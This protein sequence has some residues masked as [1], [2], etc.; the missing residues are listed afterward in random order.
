[1]LGIGWIATPTYGCLVPSGCP[2]VTVATGTTAANTVA[3]TRAALRA[4]RI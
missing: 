3:M 1:M 4:L 2:F